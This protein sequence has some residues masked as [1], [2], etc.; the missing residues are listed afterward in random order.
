MKTPEWIKIALKELDQAE[1]AGSARN[2][3]IIEYH[4][5]TALSAQSDEVPWCSSFCNWVFKQCGIKGTGSAMAR[6]WIGWGVPC[7]APVEGCVVI[8]ARGHN[9]VLG[10]VGFCVGC[11]GNNILILGG[12]Q[13]D[14][15]SIQ[16]FPMIKVIACRWPKLNK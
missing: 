5:T 1:V 4:A 2:P 11:L 12:N 3:R 14:K 9:P 7:E 16:S 13:N 6:S 10:H 8:L 15:V